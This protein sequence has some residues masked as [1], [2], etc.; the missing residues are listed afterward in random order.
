MIDVVDDGLGNASA[1]G[2]TRR[3]G[4]A[5]PA[6]ASG[7]W[8]WAAR[9]RPARS[10]AAGSASTRSCPRTRR[11][12]RDRVPDDPRRPRRRP[13]AGARRLPHAAR[14]RARH[15][16]GRRSARR[17]R[18]ARHHPSRAPRRRLDGHPHAGA[19]RTGSNARH[20]GISKSRRGAGVDP[21][22]VRDGRV[23]VRGAAL[24]CER[25]PREGHRARGP[26]PSGARDRGR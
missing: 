6:C 5:S 8:G 25:L 24:R 13:G 17:R 23:R 20:L 22:D 9:C 15:R 26:A 10:P 18:G 19:G 7:R 1:G 14:R 4:T 2:T 11:C 16:S 3:P 21:D 12:R